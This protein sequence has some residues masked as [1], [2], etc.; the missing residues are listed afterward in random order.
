MPDHD[1]TMH[2]PLAK[3]NAEKGI[4]PAMSQEQ[5]RPLQQSDFRVLIHLAFLDSQVVCPA[6][7]T[8]G[9]ETRNSASQT[10][11]G[12]PSMLAQKNKWNADSKLTANA[13]LAS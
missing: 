4:R 6:T 5:K 1:K 7:L 10:S 8:L 3:A 11:W 13:W 2:D 12:K 9:Q